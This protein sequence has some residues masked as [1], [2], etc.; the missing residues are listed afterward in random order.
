[1]RQLVLVVGAAGQL[2]TAMVERLEAE[3]EVVG[4]TRDELDVTRPEDV[5]AAVAS[6]CP[7][8]VINCSAYTNVDG[9]ETDPVTALDVNAWAVRTLAM[10]AG[11]VDATFVHFSTDFV[12]DGETDRPYVETDAPN[13]RSVYAQSKLLG[14]WLAAET[15]RHYVLR[16]ESLFGGSRGR[17]SIDRMLDAIRAGREVRAFSDRAVSPSHVDDVVTATEALLEAGAPF[18]LYHC[19]NSG[20]T[21]W[22]GVARELAAVAGRPE[23]VITPVR[24]ADASL[25]APRPLFA[26]LSNDR[27]R[28][29]GIALPSW[30]D[31]LRR[32]AH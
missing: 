20:W 16:V 27:L 6:V 18:G 11:D 2:G 10:A 26:A 28:D 19:V 22:E 9:A 25:L 31:A 15:P 13:P 3:H 4:R 12:F 23:A 32:L 17:S 30:Q 24:M 5:R 14:E 21:T 7:D 1:M 8:V 29:L